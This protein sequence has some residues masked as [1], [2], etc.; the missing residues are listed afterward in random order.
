MMTQCPNCTLDSAGN[1][2]SSCPSR[3]IY[4]APWPR[5]P[6]QEGWACPKCGWVYGPHVDGCYRCN[7]PLGYKATVRVNTMP[8]GHPRSAVVS[9]DKGTSYCSECE[10]GPPQCPNCD[11]H[12]L[13]YAYD[14]VDGV[15]EWLCSS[16]GHYFTDTHDPK[17]ERTPC[18]K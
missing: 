3:P 15:V 17:P 13:V 1:H 9:A 8:C 2:E 5:R 11:V 4:Y 7:D 16:C 12:D 6:V 18:S 14:K 10:E